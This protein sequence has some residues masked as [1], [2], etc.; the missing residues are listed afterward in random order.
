MEFSSNKVL[1]SQNAILVTRTACSCH[2]G[3]VPKKGF[4]GGWANSPSSN[5][6]CVEVSG[7]GL[8]FPGWSLWFQLPYCAVELGKSSLSF[9]MWTGGRS[10][11]CKL[12]QK[13]NS[14]GLARK[15]SGHNWLGHGASAP[16]EWEPNGGLPPG[17]LPLGL[18]LDDRQALC[19]FS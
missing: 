10:F 7:C 1:C 12:Q 2:I 9:R 19:C 13:L 15:Q 8:N 18:C 3:G 14:Q 16:A 4:Q 17:P 6:H 11:A 5:A